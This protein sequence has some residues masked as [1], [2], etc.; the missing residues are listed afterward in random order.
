[1]KKFQLAQKFQLQLKRL[2]ADLA[3]AELEV[4]KAEVKTA[5]NVAVSAITTI[6]APEATLA[7]LALAGGGMV[8]HARSTEALQG[9]VTG[10][11]VFVAGDGG[12]F[13]E[14]SEHGKERRSRSWKGGSKSIGVAAAAV[15][16]VLDLR[17]GLRS[18]KEQ[19]AR[20]SKMNLQEVRTAASSSSWLACCRCSRISGGSTS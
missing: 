1:V 9:S 11:V 5:L 16:A 13:V 6:A 19:Q 4:T 15:T 12:E 10:T 18:Y 8:V 3:E 7:K 14:L 17:T 20:R 2:T